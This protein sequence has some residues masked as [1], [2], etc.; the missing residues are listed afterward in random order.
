MSP[1]DKL[2]SIYMCD[3]T[4]MYADTE[5]QRDGEEE[6]HAKKNSAG[7]TAAERVVKRCVA[8]GSW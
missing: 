3:L 6:K 4:S 2:K 5:D 7:H 8:D 1:K